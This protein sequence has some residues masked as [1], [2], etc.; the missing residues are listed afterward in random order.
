MTCVSCG[1]ALKPGAKYCGNCGAR[2]EVSADRVAKLEL[3]PNP[4]GLASCGVRII[5]A[6]GVGPDTDGDVRFEIRFEVD[7]GTEQDW[8]HLVVRT[9]LLDNEGLAVDETRD[10]YE[11]TISA[12]ER[13]EF[14]VYHRSTR[15]QM[16]AEHAERASILV[17]VIACGGAF[18]KLEELPVPENALEV[19]Y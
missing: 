3:A 10:T 16:L 9:Q 11:Q 2:V 5:E 17:S 1:A 4:L 6:K 18:H 15:G 12:G 8:E 7:N 14:H 13:E 19:V